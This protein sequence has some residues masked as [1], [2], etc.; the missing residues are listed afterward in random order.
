MLYISFFRSGDAIIADLSRR[1]VRTIQWMLKCYYGEQCSWS[2]FYSHV[3]TPSISD[4]APFVTS[5]NLEFDE[6]EPLLPFEQLLAVL[7]PENKNFLPIAFQWLMDDPKSPIIDFYFKVILL[8][9]CRADD[10][11]NC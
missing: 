3:R 8:S 1:Y 7:P 11:K 10:D 5:T 6:A 4:M 9:T 2:W